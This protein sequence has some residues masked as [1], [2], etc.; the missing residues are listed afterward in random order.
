M[1]TNRHSILEPVG[2]KKPLEQLLVDEHRRHP[3][4]TADDLGK[5]LWQ[6]VHGGDHWLAEPDAF[7]RALIEEWAQLPPLEKMPFSALQII[8]PAG[9]TARLH[10]LGARA[11]G[12]HVDGLCAFLLGQRRKGGRRTEWEALVQQAERL[13]RAGSLPFSAAEVARLRGARGPGHHSPD[14]GFAAYRVIHD[15]TSERSRRWL[16]RHQLTP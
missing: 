6:A 14:Y 12:V 3:S 9:R 2:A 10:L 7:S 16:R 8:D 5:L 1:S 11:A 13:A 4:W 15:V